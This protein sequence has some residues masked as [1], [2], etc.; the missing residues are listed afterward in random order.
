MKNFNSNLE[1]F[2]EEEKIKVKTDLGTDHNIYY[3]DKSTINRIN[4]SINRRQEFEK[5]LKEVNS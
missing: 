1:S 2:S 3:F 5:V 4:N